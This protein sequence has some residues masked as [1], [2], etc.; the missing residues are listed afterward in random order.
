MDKYGSIK[1]EAHTFCI[2]S[3]VTLKAH[4]VPIDKIAFV[5]KT[6]GVVAA[7]SLHAAFYDKPLGNTISCIPQV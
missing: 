7:S 5:L 1:I 3:L 6:V 4:I 2:C